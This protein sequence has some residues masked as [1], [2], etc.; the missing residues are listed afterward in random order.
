MLVALASAKG[1]PGVTT[2]AVALGAIWRNEV[3]VADL[4]PAGSDI[5]ARFRGTGGQPLDPD[6]GVISLAAALRRG[7]EVSLADHL[8]VIGGGLPVL[9]GVATPAQVGGIGPVW[10]HVARVLAQ[11]PTDVLADC[12][13]IAGTSP[14]ESVLDAADRVILVTRDSVTDLAHLRVRLRS[15]GTD[16][17]GHASRVGVVVVAAERRPRAVEEVQRL[18]E[19]SGLSVPVLGVLSLDGR[20][21]DALERADALRASRSALLRSARALAATMSAST[22]HRDSTPEAAWTR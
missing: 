18:F 19:A 5:G 13:R 3:V 21:A 1:S 15:L 14:V 7:G 16:V 17:T 9:V 11:A 6:T 12:G 10:H 22:G 4:D 20:G 2:A 8:Q